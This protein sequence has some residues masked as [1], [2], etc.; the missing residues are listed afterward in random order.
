LLQQKEPKLIG[1]TI[2]TIS[3]KALGANEKHTFNC[4]EDA[5]AVVVIRRCVVKDGKATLAV[6]APL[7]NELVYDTACGKFFPLITPYQAKETIPQSWV[8]QALA[9]AL[10][11]RPLGSVMALDTLLSGRNQPRLIVAV[12]VQPCLTK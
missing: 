4:L 10:S 1:F 3:E 2:A 5:K 6:T 11:Q 8:T 12:C 7:Q 9:Q